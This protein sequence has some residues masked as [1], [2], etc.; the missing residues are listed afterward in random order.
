MHTV[1]RIGL[2]LVLI[3]GMSPGSWTQ[4]NSALLEKGIYAE[5]TL[6]N[7]SDAIST[8]LQIIGNTDAAR[9]IAVQALYRLGICYQKSGRQADAQATFS[10]LARLYPEQK[11][12]IARIPAVLIPTEIQLRPAPWQDGEVQEFVQKTKASGASGLQVLRVDAAEENGRKAWHF[13]WLSRAYEFHPGIGNVM[14]KNVVADAGSLA[15]FSSDIIGRG[16]DAH[17]RFLAGHAQIQPSKRGTPGDIPLTKMVYD[18][19]QIFQLVR[20]LPL[21]DGLQIT[22]PLFNILDG[23]VTETRVLVEGREKIA[24]PAGTLDCYRMLI[25]RGPRGVANEQ[26]VW[27]TADSHAYVAKASFSDNSEIE[28]ASAHSAPKDGDYEV[29]NPTWGFKWL[30]P[31][32]WQ[33][34]RMP[35]ENSL[36]MSGITII[37]PE[38]KAECFLSSYLWGSDPRSPK[39]VAELELFLPLRAQNLSPYTRRGEHEIIQVSGFPA[40][41]V[42][43]DYRQRESGAEM[44]DYYVVFYTGTRRVELTMQAG[45]KV[46]EEMRPVFDSIV[47]GLR[48]N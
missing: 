31:A 43:G 37:S 44:V 21:A 27:I 22:V 19:S 15:P 40:L 3:M 26:T 42:I 20:R 39:I 4:S 32:G 10:K 16:V 29:E 45:K 47:N 28:L 30:V 34:Y 6:G 12:L 1:V 5:E 11:D 33:I 35:N 17:A 41:R 36:E 2:A 18:D 24:V 8:Y 38:L 46:F 25:S 23:A 7:L 13:E 48:F 9:P 14:I